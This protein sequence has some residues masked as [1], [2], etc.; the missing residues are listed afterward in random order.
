MNQTPQEKEKKK[1]KKKRKK[2]KKKEKKKRIRIK[3]YRVWNLYHR[4]S[5]FSLSKRFGSECCH[6]AIALWYVTL[7]AGRL[8]RTHG[9]SDHY[10]HG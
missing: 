4:T 1:E 6:S 9:S 5:N 3:S 7:N 10:G 8:A 2:S